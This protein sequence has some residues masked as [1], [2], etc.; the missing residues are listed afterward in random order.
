ME[1]NGHFLNIVQKLVEQEIDRGELV[2]TLDGEVLAKSNA[3]TIEKPLLN[4]LYRQIQKQT[5]TLKIILVPNNN[6]AIN[7]VEERFEELDKARETGLNVSSVKFFRKNGLII[8]KDR[9]GI[10]NSERF[11]S[12]NG[13]LDGFAPSSVEIALKYFPNTAGLDL[14][15]ALDF[16]QMMDLRIPKG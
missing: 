4:E 16:K 8:W 6:C 10:E 7:A 12:V 5:R 1:I 14:Q 3:S 2:V 15:K 13:C 9:L 11:I